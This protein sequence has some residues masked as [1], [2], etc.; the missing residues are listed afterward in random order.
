MPPSKLNLDTD[1]PKELDEEGQALWKKLA[2]YSQE[3]LLTFWP[4]LS[5]EEKSALKADCESVDLDQLKKWFERTVESPAVKSHAK[6]NP[7]A[8][9]ANCIDLVPTEDMKKWEAR[10]LELIRENKL[11]VLLMA[12]G[13][14]TRLGS[15]KPKGMYPLELPSTDCLYGLQAK[16]IRKVQQLAS[17]AGGD[18]EKACVVLWYI[19]TSD[20]TNNET[21]AYFEA[22]G[23][24][25]IDKENVI[26]F[27]QNEIPALMDDGKMLLIEK[28]KISRS[29]D[30]NGGLYSSMKTNGILD[31][32]EQKGVGYVHIYGVDNVLVKVA[33]PRFLGYCD[34]IGV[35]V[36]AKCVVKKDPDEKVGLICKNGDRY[37]VMEYSEITDDARSR[38]NEKGDL[39][40]NAGNIVN[41]LYTFEFMKN[42][43]CAMEDQLKHHVA[44]KK[45][46]HV[47]ADGNRVAPNEP[48]GIKLE[49]FVFDVF[50]FAD[51]LAVV[52]VSREAEFS[53]LKNA[54]DPK[55][56]R[57]CVVT[58]RA[59][60]YSLH[61]KYLLAAGVKFVD[62]AGNEIKPEDLNETHVCEICPSVSFAGEGLEEVVKKSPTMKFPIYI[63]EA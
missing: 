42:K 61:R 58:C 22:N 37:E 5:S 40:F 30:G 19:M 17:A 53:P 12:G 23:Y 25:G 63:T 34:H 31:H 59:H 50:Q 26:F 9:V 36:G 38:R 33:D 27:Q 47:G 2:P 18:S 14:G 45:L 54:V 52:Q 15:K 32:M 20:G 28:N 56:P 6:L 55:N 49:K 8:D 39:V 46:P 29:P 21:K 35:E 62:D 7:V 4:S 43:A 48:N 57:D 1:P 24:W 10:G 41:H 60:L 11:A 51:S 3:Q 13:Q 16:R 44:R